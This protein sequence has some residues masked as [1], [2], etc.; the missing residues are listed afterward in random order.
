MAQRKVIWTK[1]AE[2]QF[3]GILE[4]WVKHN[5]S[6]TY[7]K[8]LLKI[9]AE[10]TELIADHPL[11]H[12]STNFKYPMIKFFR[13]IRQNLLSE[14]STGR[15]ASRTGRPAS[16]TGRYFKYALGEIVLVVL[17]IL[18]ALQINNWNEERKELNRSKDFLMEF[19]KD[20]EKDT[21][22]MN[23]VIQLVKKRIKL[24]KWALQRITYTPTQGDS[25]HS[26][27]YT[28]YFNWN[29]ETRTFRK[30]ENAGITGL[31][32][33]DSIFNAL[34]NYYDLTNYLLT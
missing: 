20:L 13:K 23:K 7:S 1:T 4:Y 14:G 16:R 30:I 15:P 21:L 19:K 8:S 32:G 28:N 12:K 31:K 5:K 29:I 11:M 6:N 2:I 22:G 34:S 25:L 24:E 3:V 10:R 33:Y 17:G 26:A 27:I 18:I 9:V